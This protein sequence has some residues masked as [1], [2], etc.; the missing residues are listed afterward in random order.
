MKTALF[1]FLILFSG[2]VN[3]G[4]T[5]VAP[6]DAAIL[7][8]GRVSF[9][10]ADEVSFDWPGTSIETRFDGT[11][12]GALFND[13]QNEYNVYIDGQY[14][15]KLSPKKGQSYYELARN[16][17]LQVHSLRIS[18]RT[19]GNFGTG[20]FNGFVLEN[21]T[22]L[23]PPMPRSERRIE[24]IGDSITAGYGNMG[25]AEHCG[26]LNYYEDNDQSYAAMLAR[27]LKADYRVI[28]ISGRGMVR[29]YADPQT[30]S[31]DPLP[32]Y[33][34][35]TLQ[36]DSSR[37]WDFSSWIPN[38]VV[39]G[40]GHNDFSTNPHPPK[41]LFISKYREFLQLIRTKYPDA[42]ALMVSREME[43]LV[44]YLTEILKLERE[45]GNQKISLKNY[46]FTDYG[47]DGHPNVNGHKKIKETLLPALAV[48]F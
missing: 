28:A 6:S 12:I 19:E 15:S 8:S 34:G 39:I 33:Y 9:S 18:K 32:S 3:A 47:C 5:T 25:P 37:P 42:S 14:Y 21:E 35:Q 48:M 30:T 7:Y 38:V 46:R 16:L 20:H 44:S 22:K 43:P 24:F 13:Q 17:K 1:L 23:L 26:S 27:E 2:V 4:Q 40:L 31:K 41:E 45:S 36:N 29:N 10:S 11:Q